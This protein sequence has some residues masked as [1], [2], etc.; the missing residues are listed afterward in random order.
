ML[1]Y[2]FTACLLKY[3]SINKYGALAKHA[4]KKRKYSLTD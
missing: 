4:D 2:E 1:T 3:M